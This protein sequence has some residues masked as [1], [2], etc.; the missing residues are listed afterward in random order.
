MADTSNLWR[1]SAVET[2]EKISAREVSCLEVI[3]SHLARMEAVNPSVNAVTVDLSDDAWKEA[4]LADQAMAEDGPIGP[5]HGV[6]ITIKENH[7]QAG[8]ATTNG[9][10][11]FENNIAEN[12]SPLVT[13]LRRAGA[14]IIGRT[15][16]PEFSLRWHTDNPLRGK[17]LN[18]WDKTITPGGSSGG[19]SASLALGIGAIAH[20]NDLGGS[21]RYPSYCCG[22]STIRPSL[23]RIPA[24]NATAPKENPISFQLMSVQ[25]PIG[26]EV[27]DVRLGLE[28]MAGKDVRDPWNTFVPIETASDEPVRVAACLDPAGVGV[29]S[30][31]KTALEQAADHLGNSGYDVDWVDPPLVRE[32]A[33]T[34][35]SLLFTE[36]KTMMQ[37]TID[38]YGSDNV[39]KVLKSYSHASN[40]VNL[41]G[42]MEC[43]A[44]RTRL[45]RAW[46][47]FQEVYPLVLCPVSQEPPM[48]NGDDL[49]GNSRV[50]EV[51]DSQSM[52]YAVNLLGLPSAAVPTGLNDGV[53]IGVQIVAP[54]FREDLALDAA[55]AIE[56]KVGILS[57]ILWDQ[58]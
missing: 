51:L 22:L 58:V 31:V 47:E 42:Y 54:R 21:L 6:P 18:P 19:A 5:L 24:Y 36:V 17:T 30:K 48:L 41:Q 26:R 38:E 33:E 23:G 25:G 43:L 34:W 8:Q 13:N 50:Q 57:H 16:T 55:E 39:K 45:I 44:N 37:P 40:L 3:E 10:P 49:S 4:E 35:R 46:A 7:D 20:G 15:N 28:I 2:A 32:I 27:R 14:I 11:A 12:D 56:S 29:D 9:L 52:L 1:L 53:P